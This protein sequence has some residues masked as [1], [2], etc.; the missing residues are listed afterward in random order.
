MRS[1]TWSETVGNLE[2]GMLRFTPPRL[3]WRVQVRIVGIDLL[4]QHSL[5]CIRCDQNRTGGLFHALLVRMRV[6]F[7]FFLSARHVCSLYVQEVEKLH[8]LFALSNKWLSII[9]HHAAL[10]AGEIALPAW[11]L[12]KGV[13]LENLSSIPKR[14]SCSAPSPRSHEK[15]GHCTQVHRQFR[16][17]AALWLHPALR[18][19]P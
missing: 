8:Q 7:D 16:H 9:S 11:T 15:R 10:V 2:G 3:N 14:R 12:R 4:A 17:A 1:W 18:P 13:A 19:W 5:F 6:I